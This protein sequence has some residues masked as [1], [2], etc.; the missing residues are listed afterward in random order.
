MSNEK[1]S[2]LTPGGPAQSTD[3]LPIAR[4]GA[5]YSLTTAQI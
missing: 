2:E 1:I 4:A 5:N 3:L